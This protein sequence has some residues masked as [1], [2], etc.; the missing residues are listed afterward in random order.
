MRG[1]SNG[2][3][4]RFQRRDRGSTPLPR[5]QGGE[6]LWQN[7]DAPLKSRTP[8]KSNSKRMRKTTRKSEKN[9][10]KLLIMA[11]WSSLAEDVRLISSRTLVRIQL[12]P[13]RWRRSALQVSE[14]STVTPSD[15]SRVMRRGAKRL[16]GSGPVQGNNKSLEAYTSVRRGG[17]PRPDTQRRD[18]TSN[19]L[20]TAPDP[21]SRGIRL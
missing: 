21:T 16:I 9:H 6:N 20:S 1:W 11:G 2:K 15:V 14:G 5:T 19:R 13:L 17:Q 18:E 12:P 10:P 4:W 7:V 8:V 3:T